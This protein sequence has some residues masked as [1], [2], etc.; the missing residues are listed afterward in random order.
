ML[1]DEFL[2]RYD[3]RERHWVKVHAPVAEVYRATRQMNLRRARL[4]RLLFNLRGIPASENFSLEDFLKMRFV[5][6]GEKPNEE[7][8][9][10]L[11]GK[12]WKPTGDLIRVEKDDFVR[13]N[14]P[15]YA[16]AVW[17]FS[18]DE[19]AKGGAVRLNTETRVFCTYAASRLQ[20]Q[21]YWFLIGAFSGLVRR[22]MLSVI[23]QT[24]EENYQ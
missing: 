5:L 13:F 6:L 3:V 19:T 11:T 20:F 10:G 22:E 4:T 9:L 16:K 7:I 14:K 1:I 21:L 24:A 18:L 17:N 2:P 12:F 15:G 23:K 8:L